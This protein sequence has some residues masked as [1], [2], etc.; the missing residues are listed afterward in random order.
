M[1]NGMPC[2]AEFSEQVRRRGDRAHTAPVP[3]DRDRPDR[4]AAE[5]YPEPSTR[6][7]RLLLS[8]PWQVAYG[9]EPA[10]PVDLPHIG[11]RARPAALLRSSDLHDQH[12]PRRRRRPGVARL[13]RLRGLR[14]RRNGARPGRPSYRV[15]V[16]GPVGEVAQVRVNRIDCGLAWARLRV[17]I[18][19]ALA[20]ALTRSRSS[21]TTQ[22]RTPSPRTSTSGGWRL[23][24][25]PATGAG[26]R[27]G[28]GPRHGQCV[29]G[30]LRVRI[31][32]SAFPTAE[33]DLQD[34]QV[35]LNRGVETWS[36]LTTAAVIGCGR[37]DRPPGSDRDCRRK[38]AHRCVRHRPGHGCC[39]RPR[40]G[41]RCRSPITARCSGRYGPRG[42]HLHPPLRARPSG[43][44]LPRG[45]RQRHR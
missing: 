16:R 35:R 2:R 39:R 14:T 36:A 8:G 17:E 28:P 27:C 26:S 40:S 15:A 4:R 38:P 19:D 25:R 12:R 32:L 21:C 29:L 42:P 10:Q 5:Q 22:R 18:S 3:G 6:W 23:R 9:N 30:L 24:A 20:A 37:L 45:R 44:R 43:D 1:S 7:R 31:V 41:C 34:A 33:Q 13:R 11:R